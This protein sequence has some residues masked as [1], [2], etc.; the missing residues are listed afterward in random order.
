MTVVRYPTPEWLEESA[1][2]Y[3]ANP[4]FQKELQKITANM[5]YRIIAKPDW[6]IDEDILFG[7]RVKNGELLELGF[8]SEEE[9]KDKADYIM[10]ATPQEWKS[11]LRKNTKFLTDFM[12]GKV[13]LELGSKVGVLGLAPHANSF[14]DALTPGE[15]QF[16][17]E[18]TPEELEQF[19]TDVAEFRAELGV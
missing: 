7:V 6:G 2:K 14:I 13:T 8:A 1:K 9:A 4:K 3:R 16:P 18:M 11:L 12:T 17:D 5:Y 15:I 19:R 10:A